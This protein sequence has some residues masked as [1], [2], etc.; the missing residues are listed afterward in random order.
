MR[1][2]Q[3]YTQ[4]IDQ[5]QRKIKEKEA[6][7]SQY[8]SQVFALKNNLEILGQQLQRISNILQQKN[9]ELA[10]ANLRIDQLS[11]QKELQELHLQNQNL[12]AQLDSLILEN[13]TVNTQLLQNQND[14]NQANIKIQQAS[15]LF[16]TAI[17]EKQKTDNLLQSYL[18]KIIM[19]FLKQRHI[20]KIR[21]TTKRNNRTKEVAEKKGQVEQLTSQI[22]ILKNLETENQTLNERVG[23]LEQALLNY[24]NQNLK[25]QLKIANEQV[26][27]SLVEY[28]RFQ[29][30]IDQLNQKIQAQDLQNEN[31]KNQYQNI[32][33]ENNEYKDKLGE[34]KQFEKEFAD[35][36]QQLKFVEEQL[37]QWKQKHSQLQDAFQQLKV[38]VQQLTVQNSDLQNKLERTS[39]QQNNQQ[40]NIDLIEQLKKQ[41]YKLQQEKT[42][43]ENKCALLS[44]EIYRLKIM[45]DNNT[46][47]FKKQQTISA[48]QLKEIELLKQ[49]IDQLLLNKNINGNQKLQIEN[50]QPQQKQQITQLTLVAAFAE[51]DS[52][53]N[54]VGTLSKD[55]EGQ[56]NTNI[57]L[58][59]Q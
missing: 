44:K 49:E 57:K 24:K 10:D 28:Q 5:L 39:N 3:H 55:L 37:S 42:Q 41:I 33:K 20:W 38:D 52:L 51:I 34:Y 50:Y 32:S 25:Q 17:N 27:Q 35:T 19:M 9:K 13:Q 11:D 12:Q 56:K 26:Q 15:F 1:I 16:Q 40:S 54:Q 7:H 2:I 58:A 23:Q 46:N 30:L 29:S 21:S 48:Q 45:N 6:V 4:L 22:Q 36:E 8:E 43:L 47:G 18:L 53:R 59:T 31:I 14:L